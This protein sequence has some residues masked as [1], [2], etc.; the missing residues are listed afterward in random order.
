[1]IQLPAPRLDGDLSLER[2][3][4]DRRSV[5]EFTDGPLSLDDLSCLLWSISGITDRSTGYRAT[6]SAG[7]IYPLELWVLASR[8]EGLEPGSWLTRCT[9][10]QSG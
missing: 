10:A 6:P 4:L 2:T 7:A 8:V 9:A 3:I 5:R 1:M